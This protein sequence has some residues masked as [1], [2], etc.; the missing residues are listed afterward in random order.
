MQQPGVR[1]RMLTCSEDDYL[2]LT[3]AESCQELFD[4]EESSR[5]GGQ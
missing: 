5:V 1:M 3:T 4:E 2:E